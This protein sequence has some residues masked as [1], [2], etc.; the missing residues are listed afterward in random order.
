MKRQ[1]EVICLLTA[2]VL[3]LSGCSALTEES[4]KRD[5][6]VL[7]G[8]MAVLVV[9][10]LIIFFV[11]WLSEFEQ[12]LKYINNEINRTEGREKKHWQKQRRRLF[13][14]IIPFIR[15]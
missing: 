15:Y 2:M 13:L 5:T 8:V 1:I 6:Y 7:I 14:S 11:N 4:A 3:A 9:I 10:L 12:E